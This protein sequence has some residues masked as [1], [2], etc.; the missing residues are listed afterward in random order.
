[1]FVNAPV[2]CQE[3]QDIPHMVK[4]ALEDFILVIG[5]LLN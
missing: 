4:L 2:V 1:V 3:K 5:R